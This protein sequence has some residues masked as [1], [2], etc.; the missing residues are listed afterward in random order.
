MIGGILT[1]AFTAVLM[2][3]PSRNFY[4]TYLLPGECIAKW[5]QHQ[6]IESNL[7]PEKQSGSGYDL[8]GQPSKAGELKG[9]PE[10]RGSPSGGERRRL[11]AF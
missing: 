6:G 11:M 7:S 9:A 2:I 8:K 5:P 1:Q 4:G 10:P 3:K